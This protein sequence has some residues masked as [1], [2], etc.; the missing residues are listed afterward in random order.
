MILWWLFDVKT[1]FLF[2]NNIFLRLHMLP[3]FL[4]HLL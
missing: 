4:F 2:L 1:D 3:F